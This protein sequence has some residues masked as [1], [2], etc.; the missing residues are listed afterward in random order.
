MMEDSVS[1]RFVGDGKKGYGTRKQPR[2]QEP[3]LKTL[4]ESTSSLRGVVKAS[5]PVDSHTSSHIFSTSEWSDLGILD[6]IVSHLESDR[7][8]GLNLAK[9]TN[10]QRQAIPEIMT[11]RDVVVK[12]ET[13]SGKTLT[14]LIPIVNGL[15]SMES[16]ISR[17]D[18]IFALIILPTRELVVQVLQRAQ[19]LVYATSW[20]VPGG[21]AGG[22]KAKSEKSRLRKGV[23]ILIGTP[24]RLAYHLKNTSAIH[25]ARLKWLVLDEADR[26]SDMGFAP[27]VDEI[28]RLIRSK[29]CEEMET[30]YPPPL[31]TLLLSATQTVKDEQIS[32]G[33]EIQLVDP[34]YIDASSDGVALSSQY[35]TPV[36]LRQYIALIRSRSKLCDLGAFLRQKMLDDS[37]DSFRI[38]VFMATCASVDFHF[39]VLNAASKDAKLSELV[40]CLRGRL[41]KLHGNIPQAE[42]SGTLK[43]FSTSKRAVLLC[44]DVAARGLDLPH[45][46]WIVQYDSPNETSEYVHRVGRAARKGNAGSALLFLRPLEAPYVKVLASHGLN[47]VQLQPMSLRL[48]LCDKHHH[49]KTGRLTTQLADIIETRMGRLQT[50]LEKLVAKDEGLK[51]SAVEG[52]KSWVRAYACHGKETRDIFNVRRLHLGH[53]AKA[54]AL[55]DPPSE[56]GRSGKAERKAK[57]KTKAK[58]AAI[59]W[60]KREPSTNESESGGSTGNQPPAS[61]RLRISAEETAAAAAAASAALEGASRPGLTDEVRRLMEKPVVRRRRGGLWRVH[62]E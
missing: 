29:R 8:G 25:L 31:Q 50:G 6:R 22:E 18:G 24:G 36:Q 51:E 3:F 2:S 11:G 27:Q 1:K 4:R 19:A 45:V 40:G 54:F 5:A 14:Y 57:A 20:I 58:R 15:A 12:S 30:E 10:V 21:I 52:F 13:G 26:L 28:R 32:V 53:V 61:K 42:R 34:V 56:I 39:E 33:K 49:S 43:S 41:L 62:S 47:V 60:P 17:S 23:N 37:R 46:E 38:I 44:T 35:Q 9:P 55:T 16:Q 59:A 48:G 7:R